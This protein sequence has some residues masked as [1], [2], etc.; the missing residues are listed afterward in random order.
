MTYAISLSEADALWSA[1]STDYRRRAKT[2]TG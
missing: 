2:D 1:L